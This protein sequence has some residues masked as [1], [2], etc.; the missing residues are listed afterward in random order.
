VFVLALLAAIWFSSRE[1]RLYPIAYGLLWFVI[2]QLPTSLY[3]L[4]EVE[5]DHRMFFSFVGLIMAVVW[6]GWLT[7]Q[8]IIVPERWAA[9]RP[10]VMAGVVVG[11]AAYGYGVHERNRVWR[12]E[13]SLWLDDVQ[14]SPANG[15]GLMNY[16]LTQM[17]KGAYPVAL[18]YFTRALQYTP[19]YAT[20]EIN[21]GIVNGAMAD[22]GAGQGNGARA[23]EAERHF[24]RAISLAPN[25]DG[26]HAYYGRW[27]DQHGRTQAALQQLQM[28]V[29]LNP[30]RVLQ[31]DL[32]IA[33]EVHAGDMDAARAAARQALA[34][35]PDDAEAIAVLRGP[36]MK[37]AAYWINLSLAQYRQAQYPESI[38]SARRAL[39]VDARSA[40]AYNNIAAGYGAMHR[41][42]EAI[43]N[44]QHA[45]QLDP[46]L[47]IAKNNL[48][49]YQQ[50]RGLPAAGVGAKSA[51]GLLDDSLHL[52]QAGRYEECIAAAQEALKLQ[53]EFPQA[54]NNIAA[55]DASL[56]RWDDAIAAAQKAIALKPD[57]QLAKNNLAWALAEKAKK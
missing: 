11:L 19:N 21:L 5:N 13:E 27:L 34:V 38:A 9:L 35:E 55:A 32:L 44:V 49:W 22:Q 52:Y 14:K 53:P 42:D 54:W 36:A 2:T 29:D 3:P 46:S 43:D 7:W 26:P 40:A 4:S 45:L 15:R 6:A 51:A 16:A 1:R 39:A 33:T 31:R 25:D 12:S 17:S 24:L 37:D 48:A 8:A 10:A 47:Q 41:W 57:F 30:S 28:A 56:H 20:L 50:Q 23:A 18:D